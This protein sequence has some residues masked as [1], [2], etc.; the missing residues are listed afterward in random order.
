MSSERHP[1]KSRPEDWD[2]LADESAAPHDREGAMLRLCAD[3]HATRLIPHA[4]A[5]LGHP[6]PLLREAALTVLLLWRGSPER[7]PPAFAILHGD[8]HWRVRISAAALLGGLSGSFPE[9]RDEILRHLVMQL[10]ADED[11]DAQ[12]G[13]YEALLKALIPE[14]ADRPKL[15]GDA[16]GWDRARDVDWSLLAPWRGPTAG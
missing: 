1:G 6:A 4:E 15:P 9:T 2:L 3:G 12:M 13:I 10:E 7:L 16:R 14:R 11:E 8:P 5:W